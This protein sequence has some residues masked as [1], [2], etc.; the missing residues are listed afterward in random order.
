[1]RLNIEAFSRHWQAWLD[2][3]DNIP[4]DGSDDPTIGN[5]HLLAVVWH[6]IDMW[7]KQGTEWDTRPAVALR[8]RA[9][10]K[11]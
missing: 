8:R 2:G 11:N 4:D 6:A 7:R 9:Q 5:N 3:E 1:M 10:E